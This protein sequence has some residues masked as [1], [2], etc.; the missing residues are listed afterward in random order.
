M[1]A[2]DEAIRGLGLRGWAEASRP[3]PEER[4]RRVSKD[5]P[6]LILLVIAS[7]AKQSRGT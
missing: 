7:A 6:S 2:G 5:A 4:R 3:R 1:A